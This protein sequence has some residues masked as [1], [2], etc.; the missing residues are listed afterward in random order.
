MSDFSFSK[1]E[2][3]TNKKKFERLF[4]SG[5]VIKAYPLKLIYISEEKLSSQSSEPP[6][7]FAFT[8]PKRNFKKAVDRNYLRR[9][10]KEVFRLN[11]QQLLTKIDLEKY[12]VFGIFIY[13][14]REKTDFHNIEKAFLKLIEKL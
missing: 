14:M 2:R 3:L 8:V 4:K 13:S 10:M 11:K 9:R 7:Q 1:S 5:V 12:S 6:F